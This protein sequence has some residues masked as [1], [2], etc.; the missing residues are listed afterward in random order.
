M[1]LQVGRPIRSYYEQYKQHLQVCRKRQTDTPFPTQFCAGK[2]RQGKER[3][4]GQVVPLLPLLPL[5]A[6]LSLLSL[7]SLRSPL[8][9]HSIRSLDSFHPNPHLCPTGVFISSDGTS[10]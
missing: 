8:S 9:V 1:R 7:L 2:A 3:Q 6:L 10:G 5:L 4:G